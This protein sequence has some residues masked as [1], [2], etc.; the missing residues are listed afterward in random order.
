[1]DATLTALAALTIV[2]DGYIQG[3]GADTFRVRYIQRATYAQLTAIA[4]AD[5]FDGMRVYVSARATAGDGA[6]GWWRFD[7]ASSTTANAGTVLAPNAGTGRWFRIDT[8]VLKPRQFG[9]AGNGSTDDSAA[10]QSLIGALVDGSQ[11][12]GEGKTYRIVTTLQ[13]LKASSVPD[14]VRVRNCNFIADGGASDD[15]F[16]VYG[17]GV[18]LTSVSTVAANATTV[19]ATGAVAGDASKWL[20]LT[21]TDKTASG[22]DDAYTSG[23]LVQI[24]SVS[25]TTITLETPTKLAYSTG[26]AAT[27]VTTIK[28]WRFENCS[29]T[30]DAAETQGGLHFYRAE[31]CYADTRGFNMGYATQYWEQSV[32][33]EFRHFG[34]NPGITTDNGT[35]YGIVAGNGCVGLTGTAR[36]YEYRHVVSLGATVAVDFC[37]FIDVIAES[38][39]DAALDSHTNVIGLNCRVIT[40]RP[41]NGGTFS[42]QPV[43]LAWQGGGYL[44]AEVTVDGYATTA[45]LIQPHMATTKDQI[46]IRGQAMNP[47]AAATRGIE[48][49]L[50]KAGGSIELID[51]DFAAEGLTAASSRGVSID[52]NNCASGVSVNNIT[53]RGHFEGVGYGVLTFQ[54][55]GHTINSIRYEGKAKQPTAGGYGW[56]M[57]GVSNGIAMG[58][59]AGCITVG[60]STAYGIRADQVVHSQAV[61]CR[62]TGVGGASLTTYAEFGITASTAGTYT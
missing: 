13:A 60:V 22:K 1:V 14:N 54:R 4:A 52:T 40:R 10:W 53:V 62:A 19:T 61:G 26:Q 31:N 30:G 58:Q 16:R 35:D 7:A 11:V 37:G 27:V 2:D 57:F 18:A 9:A 34:G 23:E 56:A 3:T 44:D 51:I 38:M 59:F 6:E 46:R 25:G 21:S 28:N 45:V 49:D 50:Y 32:Y 12:D 15:V 47:T 39:K 24:R 20:L 48:C 33:S 17:S 43:G 8:T 55:A 42:S 29:F 41:R 5:R 36:G